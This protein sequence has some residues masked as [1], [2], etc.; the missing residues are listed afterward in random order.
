MLVIGTEK[1][2]SKITHHFA[3]KNKNCVPNLAMDVMQSRSK[4][5]L[6]QFG[7]NGKYF[8]VIDKHN[9]KMLSSI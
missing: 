6:Y 5:K 4:D 9:M 3:S 1:K 2:F 7:K 8:G